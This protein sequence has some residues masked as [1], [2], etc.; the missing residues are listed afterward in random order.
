[1]KS[2]SIAGQQI[3]VSPLDKSEQRGLWLELIAN[4]KIGKFAFN[5][6]SLLL[7]EQKSGVEYTPCQLRKLSERIEF[8]IHLPAVFYFEQL[9]T[10]LR[11]RLVE[12]GVYFIASDRYAFVPTLIINRRES[13]ERI[14]DNLTP[15]AQYILLYHLQVKSL[16][17]L[18]IKELE[19]L[20]LYKYKTISKSLLQL[21]YHG[22]LSLNGGKDKTIVIDASNRDLWNK[23]QPYL[24]NPIKA[25]YY[26][27]SVFN[28]GFIGGI[29]ALSH[30]SMLAPEDVPTRVLTTDHFSELKK[31]D[32]PFLPFEDIQRIE[33][34]KYP[35]LSIDGYV[36]T[37]SLYL[38]LKED[39]DPRVEK[40]LETMINEMSW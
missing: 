20:V 5:N 30:Y 17:G 39:K 16:N 26:S 24:I 35:P 10:Y 29:S 23:A 31:N 22:L 9:P 18:S 32:Y 28:A 2:I 7:F 34:W 15:A 11:D 3:A 37:L 21:Q 8:T 19:N 6:Q 25:D 1:M 12:Q 40:E 36:D 13:D 14:R 33:V 4:F 27:S 38:T